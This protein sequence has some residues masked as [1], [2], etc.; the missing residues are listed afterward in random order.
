MA[1]LIYSA[2]TSLDGQVADALG[3]F[4]WAMPDEQVHSFVNELERPLG[5]YLYGRRMYEVMRAWESWPVERE[6]SVTRDFAAIWRAADKIVY[7]RTLDSV[8]TERD[9]SVGG[10]SL[11][12]H[13][14]HAGLV[15]EFHQIVAPVVVGGGTHWLPADLSLDLDLVEERRFANGMVSLR[16]RVG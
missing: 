15:T 16:Y 3:R 1:R 13:A 12:A 10:S 5:T 7:S 2:I 14:L 9:V 6:S 11:A 4:D 8:S